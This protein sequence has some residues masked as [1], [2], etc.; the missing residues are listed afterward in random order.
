MALFLKYNGEWTALT[1]RFSSTVTVPQSTI[2]KASHSTIHSHINTQMWA[3]FRVK[4]FT[5]G[6]SDRLGGGRDLIFCWRA[7]L[8]GSR[9]LG[10]FFPLFFFAEYTITKKKKQ[11][12]CLIVFTTKIHAH[13]AGSSGTPD[14]NSSDISEKTWVI[15]HGT[16]LGWPRLSPHD[17]YVPVLCQSTLS[18][19]SRKISLSVRLLWPNS[20]VWLTSP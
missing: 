10:Q 9:L 12:W 16:N 1:S 18:A 15:A 13:T 8:I 3:Q 19:R 7:A 14:I 11:I 4:C 17:L 20:I 5:E 2:K 6:H